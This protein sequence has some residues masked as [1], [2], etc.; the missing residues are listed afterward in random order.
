MMVLFLIEQYLSSFFNVFVLVLAWELA[1][2]AYFR[3]RVTSRPLWVYVHL[4]LLL[5]PL[6]HFG[7]TIQCDMGFFSGLASLCSS[8]L[9]KF[10][11]FT[12]P[13]VVIISIILGFF[14]MPYVFVK[15]FRAKKAELSIMHAVAG[16]AGMSA[17]LLYLFDSQEPKAFTIFNRVFAS[18][19]LFDLLSRK[20]LEA[21]FLH[22]LG[23]VR[24]GSNWRKFSA[25]L[26]RLFSPLAAFTPLQVQINKE[27]RNADAFAVRLQGT[28][29]FLRSAKRKIREFSEYAKEQ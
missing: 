25:L 9:I 17:P 29:R 4:A 28:S 14:I 26:V 20:E 2:V 21:V 1:L 6:V 12:L 8:H 5:T 3:W 16:R 23:H 24:S 7:A 10:V 18:V 11:L 13:F 19:G 22:E 15:N 27:E